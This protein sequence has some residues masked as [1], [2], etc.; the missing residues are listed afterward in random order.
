MSSAGVGSNVAEHGAPSSPLASVFSVGLYETL[1]K[2]SCLEHRLGSDRCR[3]PLGARLCDIELSQLL[4]MDLTK[5]PNIVDAIGLP[6]G[7]LKMSTLSDGHVEDIAR[8]VA[9]A[10]RPQPLLL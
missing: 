2:V 3:L 5:A 10:S 1:G 9:S 7:A 4:L 6:C 8:W